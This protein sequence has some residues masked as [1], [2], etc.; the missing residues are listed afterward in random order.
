[1]R[2]CTVFII[3]AAVVTLLAPSAARALVIEAD[4]ATIHTAGMAMK[5]G[6]NLHSNGEVGDY[7]RAAQAGDYE[8]VIRAYGSPC[9][10]VWPV[11]QAVVD[12]NAGASLTVG[13]KEFA[14]YTLKVSLPAGVHTVA[15]AFTNDAMVGGEDRNLYL[16]RLELRPLAGAKDLT[17]GGAE[18][19]AADAEANERAALDRA[20]AGAEEYRKGTATVR[21]VDA[22]GKPAAGASVKVE[23][24]RHEFL[25]GC[26]I[27]MFD[28]F[29]T[30][31]EN[32]AYKQRFADLFNFATVG[33]YW[34]SYEPERGKPNYAYTDQVVAWASEH[35]IRLK[36]HP[37][38]WDH[39]AGVPRWSTGQPATDV[40][41]ARVQEIVRRYAGRIEFWEVVN[42][43][44]H[45][46]G[47]K[48]NEPYRW[49]READPKAAL[50]V[51]DYYVMANGYPPFFDLLT[52]AKAAGVPF[53]GIG[54]QAHEPRA[55]RFAL[56]R[57]QRTLDQYAT[58]GKLLYITEFSPASGGEKI[59][60]SH[61]Q[62]AWDEAAQAEY[63]E[64]F[65][66][67]AFGHPAVAG[68]TWWDLCDNGS[69]L[70][71]GGMLRADLT[72]KPVYEAL[73]RLIHTE[74]QTR[75]AGKTDADGK[76]TFRGFRGQ[77]AVNVEAGAGQ[78]AV[79]G[80]MTKEG[81]NEWR[82]SVNP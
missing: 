4:K 33:F 72:P 38:L 20:A 56:D 23:L 76:F 13:T 16:A 71:G 75:V 81:P 49:A 6:W 21:V 7:V 54:I 24:V 65:Y 62:G 80:V 30:A 48:I 68:I 25:F 47:V 37:L 53:D 28:R 50:I 14:D 82:V 41:K 31:T 22:A 52:K 36:G 78:F 66:R 46:T 43:P 32:N 70:K 27:Y 1:V 19:W 63:A 60:G 15:V 51:N 26:N 42:E 3:M 57:V 8:L 45:A 39:E 34:Q 29:K 9:Q 69:W 55:E 64:R 5:G 40:Q 61:R 2:R 17:L 11:A 59:T 79:L 10:G 74:W 58:L 44:A 12:G 77:Y 18:A 35:A 67:V 73:Q